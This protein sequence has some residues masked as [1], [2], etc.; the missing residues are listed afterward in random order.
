MTYTDRKPR[1]SRAAGTSRTARANRAAAKPRP[2]LAVALLCAGAGVVAWLAPERNGGAEP[3][4]VLTGWSAGGYRRVAEAVGDAPHV[5][6]SAAAPA[7][8]AGLVVLGLLLV[9]CWW[10]ARGR[11]AAGQVAGVALAG[12]GTVL[13]YG[14][15]EVLKVFLD[16]ERP[17]RALA[18]LPGSAVAECP[19]PGD[20]SFPSNHAT[21][22]VAL[23]TGLVLLRPRWALL[24]IPV[25]GA[26]AA[27]RV[28]AGVHYPHDV[29]AGAA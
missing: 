1:N 29:L 26:T 17:C 15:S 10:T 20:W 25:G 16:E 27:L 3:L 12:L 24:V 5:V 8:E 2:V 11:R 21:L 7:T 22:A 19:P 4:R 13:A 28:A 9:L 6:A 18:G 14:A 23:A